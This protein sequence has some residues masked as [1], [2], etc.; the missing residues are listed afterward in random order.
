MA[1]NLQRSREAWGDVAPELLTVGR[2][3]DSHG[4]HER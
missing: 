1:E 2:V 4:Q 3:N